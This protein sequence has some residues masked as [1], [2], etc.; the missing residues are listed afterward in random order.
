[1]GANLVLSYSNFR[2]NLD[3]DGRP[4]A[5]Q[6]RLQR[7][8]D[9]MT[10]VRVRLRQDPS[11]NLLDNRVDNSAAPASSRAS[12]EE[13]SGQ[14]QHALEVLAVPLPTREVKP[15]QQWKAWRNLPI[16]APGKFEAGAVDMTYTYLG[17]R[18]NRAGRDEAVLS[19]A[20][21]VQGREGE[22]TS[23]GG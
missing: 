12:T 19:L 7:A 21:V 20:G 3:G 11:G 4:T 17:K 10:K 18:R 2:L 13:L 5:R 6:R 15:G 16:G 22:E 8:A 9:Q 14:M 1:Q 23:V